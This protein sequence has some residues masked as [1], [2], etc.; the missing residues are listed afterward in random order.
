MKK[1]AFPSAPGAAGSEAPATSPLQLNESASSAP[2][3]PVRT[4]TRTSWVGATSSPGRGSRNVTPGATST[5]GPSGGPGSSRGVSETFVSVSEGT[6]RVHAR[7]RVSSS[8]AA[9]YPGRA[10]SLQPLPLQERVGAPHVVER[11]GLPA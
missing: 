10:P 9:F 1:A 2:S 3:S 6:T 7:E 8:T 5:G 11:G 4:S